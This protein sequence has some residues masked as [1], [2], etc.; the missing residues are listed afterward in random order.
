MSLKQSK[1]HIGKGEFDKAFVL[2]EAQN[3]TTRQHNDFISLKNRYYSNE[4]DRR[5]NFIDAKDYDLRKST[6]IRDI[7]HLIDE[8]QTG[9][10]VRN[11]RVNMTGSTFAKRRF[12]VIHQN[13]EYFLKFESQYFI[14]KTIT[15]NNQVLKSV[16][17]LFSY[18]LQMDFILPLDTENQL[19]AIFDI[20]FNILTGGIS[21]IR[22]A[23]EN[24]TY[25]EE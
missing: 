25:Y 19:P 14:K 23:I 7:L 24:E 17:N 6:A 11:L 5:N 22:L 16:I 2:I 20:R 10:Q 15:L 3:L 12:S 9:V 8:L 21:S 1:I 18:R 4:K 13:R